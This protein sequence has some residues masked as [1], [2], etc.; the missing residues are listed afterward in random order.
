MPGAV[1]LNRMEAEREAAMSFRQFQPEHLINRQIAG[2]MITEVIG[3]GAMSEVVRGQRAG[4]SPA[5]HAGQRGS[6]MSRPE[7]AAIKLLAP[8]PQTREDEV[9]DVERRFARE[10]EAL[11]LLAH[12]HILPI[13]DA[14]RDADAGLFYIV[15]PFMSGGSLAHALA[16]R[17][18]PPLPSVAAFL[19]Q[20]A[21]ALD[22]AHGQGIVHRD[23]KPGNILL[24]ARGAPYLG[25]FGLARIVPA[26]L[27]AQTTIGRVLG[28]PA[29]MAPEQISDTTRVGPLTDLYGL[30]MV[31]YQLVTGHVAFDSGS[32]PAL[33]YKSLNER[34]VSPRRSCPDLP[35]PAAAAILHALEK[36]PAR[37]FA[38]A[39]AFAQAFTLGMQDEWAGEL[40]RYAP[41]ATMPAWPVTRVFAAV[42]A[43][44][45]P[46]IASDSPTLTDSPAP[47]ASPGVQLFEP[48]G[49]A[50]WWRAIIARCD[51]GWWSALVARCDP[52]RL[53]EIPALRNARA[54]VAA[55]LLL[56]ACLA[57]SLYLGSSLAD[58]GAS[59]AGQP[60]PPVNIGANLGM[61]AASIHIA[62]VIA[63]PAA[64]PSSGAPGNTSHPA[65]HHEHHHDD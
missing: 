45:A 36:D 27:T 20:I 31:A 28:S 1:A 50:E 7:V 41:G 61:N 16:T 39:T 3:A 12:P 29:Y 25:D 6:L 52:S 43:A 30:G 15:L 13:V 54:A 51:P 21:D 32:L 17:G 63:K 8:P 55:A 26:D 42:R 14:G 57:G 34:P 33:M 58:S 59:Q 48:A 49:V 10:A 5:T 37:R 64:H 22:F 46:F 18:Q 35:E 19:E 38:S 56:A 4:D 24:D 11:R 47:P 40:E 62:P 53:R 9:A 2:Y 65:H 44:A 23:I 60:L